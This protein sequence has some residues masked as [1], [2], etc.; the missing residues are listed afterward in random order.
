[1]GLLDK[2]NQHFISLPNFY[3]YTFEGKDLFDKIT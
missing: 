3:G 2:Y 1:M